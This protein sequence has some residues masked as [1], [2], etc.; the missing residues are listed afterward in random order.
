MK[1][2]R[3]LHTDTTDFQTTDCRPHRKYIW[4]KLEIFNGLVVYCP[5]NGLVVNCRHYYF[6]ELFHYAVKVDQSNFL[7]HNTMV[8]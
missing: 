2:W 6:V 1:M 5:F 8:H 3:L 7:L 4:R